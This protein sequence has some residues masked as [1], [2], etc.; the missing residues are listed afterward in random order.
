MTGFPPVNW[1]FAAYRRE[2]KPVM[3]LGMGK[4]GAPPVARPP[5]MQFSQMRLFICFAPMPSEVRNSIIRVLFVIRCSFPVN[6]AKSNWAGPG[7][8]FLR[9]PAAL[10]IA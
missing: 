10:P 6:C 7:H 9:Q 4:A 8:G 1:R 5:T 2:S 3:S